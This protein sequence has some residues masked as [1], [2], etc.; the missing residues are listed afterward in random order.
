M[1]AHNKFDILCTWPV[2]TAELF[3][4]HYQKKVE[5]AKGRMK[6]DIKMLCLLQKKNYLE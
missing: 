1:D 3:K 2:L 5:A 4:K 6:S